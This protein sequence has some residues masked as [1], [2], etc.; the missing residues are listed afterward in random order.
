VK[1]MK[2]S[3]KGKIGKKID[4]ADRQNST[5]TAGFFATIGEHE[6]FTYGIVLR[7]HPVVIERI[8][9]IIIEEIKEND[10]L[11]LSAKTTSGKLW[12]NTKD[13]DGENTW[14]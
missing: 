1:E 4:A 10:G 2:E 9:K 5:P 12:L 13:L 8:N 3:K 14:G 6:W 7:A 11:V